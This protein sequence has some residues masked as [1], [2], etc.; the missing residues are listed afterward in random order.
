VDL[1]TWLRSI[2]LPAHASDSYA[3][4]LAERGFDCGLVLRTLGDEDLERMGVLM[5]HRRVVL[6]NLSTGPELVTTAPSGAAKR[7]TSSIGSP[8]ANP[9]RSRGQARWILHPEQATREA[10]QLKKS[11]SQALAEDLGITREQARPML[12]AHASETGQGSTSPSRKQCAPKRT[13]SQV[14]AED[15]GITRDQARQMIPT[16]EPAVTEAKEIATHAASS[17]LP[18]SRSQCLAADTG[19]DLPSAREILRENDEASGN[20]ASKPLHG[21]FYQA[22]PTIA[23]LPGAEAAAGVWTEHGT[24]Q[25]CNSGSP[26]SSMIAGFDLDSTLVETKS[27]KT[28]AEHA[29]DWRWWHDSVPGKLR[30]LAKEGFKLVV[31]TNQKG[32]GTG[33]TPLA[34]FRRRIDAIQLS[35]GVPLLTLAATGDDMFRKPRT[36]GWDYLIRELNGDKPAALGRCIF[37]GDAAG[38]RAER[39]HKRDFSDTDLKFALNLGVRFHTPESFFLGGDE[40]TCP[41]TFPFDPRRLGD[42]CCALPTGLGPPPGAPVE[43]VVVVG[44]PGAGKSWLAAARFAGYTRAN[45]DLLK[46]RDRCL[47]VVVDSLRDGRPAIVDNTNRDAPTR[48]CYLDAAKAA[49]VAARAVVVDIPVEMCMHLNRYRAFSAHLPEHRG[50]DAVPAPIIHKFFKEFVRPSLDEGFAEIVTVKAEHFRATGSQG[51]LALL[52]CFLD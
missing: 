8:G 23:R 1:P 42:P 44:A 9:K 24:L 46:T 38:R 39:G 51:D 21:L 19:L 11:P 7:G 6:K 15:L 35:A 45:Q 30:D 25:I 28:F 13:A 5:G 48:K 50:R 34:Q 26:A 17:A 14:L 12:S 41:E 43:L 10:S 52:R 40:R 18:R 33:T 36:G 2:G 3:A 47:R 4:L 16:H 31:F 22:L 37:V 29:D 20:G 27:G 32:V 49:G